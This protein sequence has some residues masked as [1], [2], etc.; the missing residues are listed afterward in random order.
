M[1]KSDPVL[2]TEE[3]GIVWLTLNRPEALNALGPDMLEAL[4]SALGRAAEDPA[5]RAVIL[6]GAGE[7]AFSAGAD[8]AFLNAADPTAVRELARTAVEVTRRIETLGKVV[9]AAINGYAL[10]G[11]LELAEACMVRVAARGV[12][13]G[14]PEVRIGAIAG[15]GGTTRLPRLVGRG[16]AA[17]LL[18]TGAMIDADEAYRIGLVN[19]VVDRAMLRDEAERLARSILANSPAA[20]RLTWEAMHRGLSMSLEESALLGADLF[21]QVAA[22]EDFREGTRAFLDRGEPAQR[23]TTASTSS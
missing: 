21:G 9:V 5:V 3:G 18:L 15:W 4:L 13:L 2:Y 20:V 16:R 14:H 23:G 6:T 7:K 22:T 8:I 19:R 1:P 10:G 17:E 12:R 11:G